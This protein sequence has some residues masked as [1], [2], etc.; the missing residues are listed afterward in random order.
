MNALSQRSAFTGSLSFLATVFVIIVWRQKFS[1]QADYLGD[2]LKVSLCIA[3]STA[4]VSFVMWTLTHLKRAPSKQNA[5]ARGALAGFLT[6]LIIIP[7]PT[8]AWVLKTEFL[9]AYHAGDTGLLS[10]ALKAGLLAIKLGLGTFIEITK[11]AL[12]AIIGSSCL[13]LGIAHFFGPQ[14]KAASV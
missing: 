11:A 7:L 10:A 2:I 9:S 3:I 8:A 1:Y 13:G 14:A 12:V 5:Y 4:I 6:A